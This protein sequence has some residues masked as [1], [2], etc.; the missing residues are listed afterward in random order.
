M[1]FCY[2]GEEYRGVSRRQG[3]ILLQEER[4]GDRVTLCYRGVSRRQGDILLQRSE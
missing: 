1:T 4:V 3:D 2:K